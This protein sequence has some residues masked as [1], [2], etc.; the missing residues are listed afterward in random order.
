MGQKVNPLSMRVGIMKPWGARWYADKNYAEYLH[1]DLKIKKEVKKRLYSAGVSKIEISRAATKCN[2]DIYTARP[3]VVIGKRGAGIDSLREDLQTMTSKEIS[4]N[5]K[6]V[7][8]A[9]IDAQL[10][11]ENIALQLERRVAFRR[12][13]KRSVQAALKLGAKGVK[14]RVAGRLGGAEIARA[15]WYMEG[16]VPLHTLK[17]D[18]DYGFIEANTTYGKIGVKVWVNHGLIKKRDTKVANPADSNKSNQSAP[19]A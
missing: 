18:I 6:E 8:K 17:A 11:S 3:G 10:V 1:E 14:V 4:L 9:E 2:V 12:V 13:M 7:R 15:E 16:S 5:I 19:A